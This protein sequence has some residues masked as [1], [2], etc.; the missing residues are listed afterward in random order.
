MLRVD[1][2]RRGVSEIRNSVARPHAVDIQNLLSCA[3]TKQQNTSR[4]WIFFRC[5]SK[6]VDLTT[7]TRMWR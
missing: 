2:R 4:S 6:N 7:K 5:E 1:Q 3:V